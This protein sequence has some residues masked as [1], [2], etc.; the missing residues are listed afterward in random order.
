MWLSKN[1]RRVWLAAGMLELWSCACQW[2][3]L[4]WI[5]LPRKHVL[6]AHSSAF[7]N[8]LKYCSRTEPELSRREVCGPQDGD[9][10]VPVDPDPGTCSS[11]ISDD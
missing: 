7:S 3:V 11:L 8:L 1:M 5:T 10:D 2:D 4:A 9:I 6:E